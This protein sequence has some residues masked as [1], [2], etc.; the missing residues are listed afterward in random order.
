MV[1]VLGHL[2]EVAVWCMGPLLGGSIWCRY[3]STMTEYC[4]PPCTGIGSPCRGSS[5][6]YGVWGRH[7]Y[8]QHVV[9]GTFR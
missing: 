1:Q 5:M 3:R 4:R 8:Q 2:A 9:S 6:V 7:L